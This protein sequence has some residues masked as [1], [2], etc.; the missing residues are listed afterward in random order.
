MSHNPGNKPFRKGVYEF[1]WRDGYNGND[2][3]INASENRISD[4]PELIAQYM[5]GYK[6]GAKDGNHNIKK[7]ST[8]R[9]NPKNYKYNED[10]TIIYG[11]GWTA[12]YEKGGGGCWLVTYI[13]NGQ[14]YE[15]I[16]HTK[17]DVLSKFNSFKN[18]IGTAEELIL[19]AHKEGLVDGKNHAPKDSYYTKNAPRELKLSYLD[20]YSKGKRENPKMKKNSTVRINPTNENEDKKLWAAYFNSLHNA[21]REGF[22]DGN[23]GH[24]PDIKYTENKQLKSHYLEGFRDGRDTYRKEQ[25]EQDEQENPKSKKQH[26]F[27][28]FFPKIKPGRP[29]GGPKGGYWWILDIFDAKDRKLGHLIGK[30]TK[31]KATLDAKY[32]VGDKYRGK[33]I[34]R[35]M[36]SGPYDRKPTS[37]TKRK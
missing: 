14:E 33:T 20:G 30:G 2:P 18:P 37:K 36:L 13:S 23:K 15:T 31:E 26:P 21:Y 5:K 25:H 9:I 35:A 22:N 27:R 17:Q 12:R 34:E 3:A 28:R 11:K 19:R 32:K 29:A 10:K 24:A 16:E 1:G 6:K 8:V 4:D 7:N